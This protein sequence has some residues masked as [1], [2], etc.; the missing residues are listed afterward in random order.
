MIRR[1]GARGDRRATAD[2]G[3]RLIG[4]G[5]KGMG[6]DELALIRK[7]TCKETWSKR[8]WASSFPL[9]SKG[10]VGKIAHDILGA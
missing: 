10:A 1:K 2:S 6:V 8:N 5:R 7:S 3:A 9:I 4:N